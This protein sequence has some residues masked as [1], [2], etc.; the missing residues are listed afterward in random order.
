[1]LE[2]ILLGIVQGLTE[3]LPIS[4]SGHLEI[5][6][7]LLEDDALGAESLLMTICLHTATAL[8][9]MVVYR[10]D[11]MA[12]LKGLKDGNQQSIKFVSYIVISMIPAVLVGLLLQD[13]IESL[14]SKNMML[15][16]A[17]LLV[18]GGLLLLASYLAQKSQSKSVTGPWAFL[19]GL[20]QAIAILPGISR[21]GATISTLLLLGVDRTASAR[22]S[23]LMVI[24]LIFGSMAKEILGGDLAATQIP[25][26]HL[27][28]GF[29][30]AFIT[31]ILACR[32]MIAIVQRTGLIYFG[33][34]CLVAGVALM[35][36]I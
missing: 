31:G 11:I 3:F 4:S 1:M 23:F 14:F 5:V 34:Y 29:C 26:T 15:I 6:R 20:A 33:I 36:W 10:D 2:A 28:F 19:V 24:P 35:L 32:L 7:Y 21:S 16:G 22:F 9:T 27:L 30:A 12:L 17:M 13:Q 18:T 25:W 8:A